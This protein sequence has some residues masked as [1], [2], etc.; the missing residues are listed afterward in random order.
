MSGDNQ[1]VT[2]HSAT[3]Q[4][5]APATY[6]VVT[7]V[8]AATAAMAAFT[9]ASLSLPVWAMFVGWVAYFTRRPSAKEG[10][11]S[12]VCVL[13]GLV[14]GSAAVLILGLLGPALGRF[15][16]PIVVFFIGGTVII[17]RGLPVLN[18]LLGYF[19]GLITFFA[20]HLE[21]ELGSI[22]QLGSAT[23]LGSLAGWI[24]Q[25]L[26]GRARSLIAA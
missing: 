4:K 9:S 8:L 17:T 3:Q 20:S 15:A 2:A 13:I 25:T 12:F 26:E 16:L 22:G 11:H 18:N 5:P 7:M 23:A 6:L 10:L 21:P 24:G 14:L 1:S 19:L